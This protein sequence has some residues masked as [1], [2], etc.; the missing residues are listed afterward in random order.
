MWRT[1]FLIFIALTTSISGMLLWQWKAYSKQNIPN[2]E[3]MEKVVQEI[4]IKT[5]KDKLHITQKLIGLTPDKE[6]LTTV[7]DNLTDW[8]CVKVDGMPCDSGDENP[9]TF[10]PNNDEIQFQY[11]VLTPKDNTAFLFNDWTTLLPEVSVVKT[12]IEIVDTAKREGSW[13][14]GAPLKGFMEM[15]L[16][17]FY[18]FSSFGGTPSLYW[19]PVP[20]HNIQTDEYIDYY[21]A[22][23]EKEI[24]LEFNEISSLQGFPYAAVILSDEYNG[25]NGKGLVFSSPNV[26]DAEL[27]KKLTNYYFEQR[28]GFE[29][30]WLTDI[31]T[32]YITKQPIA[33]ARGKA[34]LEQLNA[35]LSE[36][37]ITRFYNLV[38]GTNE[39]LTSQDLDRFL[40][41]I[42]RADTRFFTMN[43]D[44][45]KPFTPLY[46]F[47]ARK[48]VIANNEDKEIEVIVDNGRMLYPFIDTMTA[49]GFDL[50][51]L[52]DQETILL[53]KESNSYR[54]YLN[55]NIFIY[56]EEDYGLLESPLT[57]INGNIYMSKEWI[58]TIF[59]VTFDEGEEEIKLSL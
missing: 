19:Q 3:N 16:I 32:A 35:K 41:D 37:E 52:P 40:K 47:D 45:A 43:K 54:F 49:L 42:K 20:L 38:L 8:T 11:N 7:S 1:A 29:D 50:K 25:M 30:K 39:L 48:I 6:Y 53:M 10:L 34:V 59:K 17:D 13:V 58:Q 21:F 27:A 56:N 46:F 15:D 57:N 33:T 9:H 31:F 5:D 44:E 24:T 36:E 26:T 23:Q 55:S 14:A 51:I 12:T 2:D 18:L 22:S 28:N 4:L